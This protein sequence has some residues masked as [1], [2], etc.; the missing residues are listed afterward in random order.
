MVMIEVFMEGSK[1][2]T[3]ELRAVECGPGLDR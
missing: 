2:Y 1:Q 3:D